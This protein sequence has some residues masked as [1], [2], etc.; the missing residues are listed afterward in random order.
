MHLFSNAIAGLAIA[1]P[2]LSDSERDRFAALPRRLALLVP[3]RALVD[4]QYEVSAAIHDRLSSPDL[5]GVLTRV[6][7]GLELRA[8][9]NL[10][11]NDDRPSGRGEQLADPLVVASLRGGLGRRRRQFEALWHTRPEATALLHFTPDLFGSGILFRRY[12]VRANRRPIDAGLLAYDTVAVVDEAHLQQQLTFTARRV[13]DLE[14]ATAPRIGRP[15]LQVV[16]TSA[17][18]GTAGGGASERSRI[19]VLP[20]DLELDTLL[21]QR[22]Q[23]NKP[24]E[25]VQ[26]EQRLDDAKVIAATVDRLIELA[27]SHEGPIGLIV[28]TVRAAVANAAALRQRLADSDEF[29]ADSV[30]TVVGRL[31]PIDRVE[32]LEQQYPGAL[33]PEGNPEVKFIVAT[34]T[35]EVGVDLDLAALVTEL[36]SASALAQRAGRVNRR[37]L[38]ERGASPIIVLAP[39][40][41]SPVY[42]PEELAAARTWLD[43]LPDLSPASIAAHPAPPRAGRQASAAAA[44]AMGRRI[45]VIHA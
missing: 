25:V 4:S 43:A 36:P 40:R 8:G 11:P 38:P 33:T 2:G 39:A 23:A 17:T 3:R 28:N 44:G 37:G 7:R 1:E 35:L 45:P 9:Q 20:D 24:I 26:V 22:L 32:K 15:V 42:G 5:N 6:R 14:R 12:G 18:Q 16:S 34:Q 29:P 19:G 30:L 13:A 21:R 31:R 41:P 27:Q 10:Q